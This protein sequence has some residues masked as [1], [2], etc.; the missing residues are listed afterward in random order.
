MKI[1]RVHC[2]RCGDQVHDDLKV[3]IAWR[4]DPAGIWDVCSVGCAMQVLQ[5]L[6]TRHREKYHQAHQDAPTDTPPVKGEV[7]LD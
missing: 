2:D 3:T 1:T 4:D 7:H 5:E 6:Y